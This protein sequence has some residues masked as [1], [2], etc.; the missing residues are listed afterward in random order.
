MTNDA[1]V[2]RRKNGTPVNLGGAKDQKLGGSVRLP[3]ATYRLVFLTAQASGLSAG[4]IVSQA[5]S[6]AFDHMNSDTDGG[7]GYAAE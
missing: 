2:L 3:A 6:Y 4:E 1:F 7:D 5:V